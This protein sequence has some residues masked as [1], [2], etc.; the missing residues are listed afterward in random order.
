MILINADVITN[1]I[2]DG[3][4]TNTICTCD[5]EFC[6]F[7]QLMNGIS[8]KHNVLFVEKIFDLKS[9]VKKIER[10]HTKKS[11]IIV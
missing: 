5:H 1:S 3:V 10:T 4:N 9:I 8:Q 7:W 6:I 11:V 2:S